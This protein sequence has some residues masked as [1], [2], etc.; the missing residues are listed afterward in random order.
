M[1]ILSTKK[2]YIVG[3][4]ALALGIVFTVL[5]YQ[6]PVGVSFVIYAALLMAGLF[7]LL[8]VCKVPY[9]KSSIWFVPGIL[10]FSAMVAVRDNDFLQF[11][12][13]VLTIGLLL[14]L[15]H[16]LTGQR[17]KQYLF[18]DYIK[19]AVVLPFMMLGKAFNALGR[20]V[21][22]GKGTKDSKKDPKLQKA[23]S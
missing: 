21:S 1:N 2:I 6:K 9:T 14:L 5:F 17:V 19:T 13:S 11:F 22:V 16:Q 12:S 20:M 4:L 10:F 7:A 18:V 23:F 3:I 15:G 8:A